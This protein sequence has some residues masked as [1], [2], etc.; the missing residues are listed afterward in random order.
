[1][2]DLGVAMKQA[3]EA[4]FQKH[5]NKPLNVN[6]DDLPSVISELN[7]VA[8]LFIKESDFERALF[9]LKKA[10]GL[11]DVTDLRNCKRDQ[12]NFFVVFHNMAVCYQ[13]T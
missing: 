9:L 11:I 5:Y 2:A 13:K 10:H 12:F 4:Y 3:E 6:K 7:E 1:M 8:Y